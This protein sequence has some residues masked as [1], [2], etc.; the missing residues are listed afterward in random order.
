[1]VPAQYYPGTLPPPHPG[2]TMLT[3]GTPL[4]H[5]RVCWCRR[6]ATMRPWALFFG[7]SL[8]SGPLA[9][10]LLTNLFSFVSQ[11]PASF[12]DASGIRNRRSDVTGATRLLA[13]LE[14]EGGAGTG[15]P[16]PRSDDA[17][18]YATFN[19]FMRF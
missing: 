16:A 3:P 8:G 7:L 9:S 14:E 2:Y 11:D 13:A 4:L 19:S 1:M 15:V 5:R 12:P 6:A 10:L 18:E 17:R